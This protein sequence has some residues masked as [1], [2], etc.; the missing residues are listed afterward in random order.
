MAC[1]QSAVASVSSRGAALDANK[2][3]DAVEVGRGLC[4]SDQC[5]PTRSK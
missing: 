2:A 5:L 3:M 1:Q 4:S